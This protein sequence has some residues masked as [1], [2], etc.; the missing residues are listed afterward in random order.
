MVSELGPKIVTKGQPLQGAKIL[1]TG[2]AGQIAW[3]LCQRL[4][5]ANEVWGVA[6]FSKPG[7]RE[8]CERIGVHTVAADLAEGDLS[9]VPTDIDYLLHLAASTGGGLD[10]DAAIRA[11]AEATG[12]ILQHCRGVTAALVM[13]TQSV[14]EP[15][16]DPM[17]VFV[18]TDPLGD[19]RPPHAP[20]YGVSKLMSEGVA[21]A[22]SRMFDIPMTIARMNASYG[23]AGGLPI[24]HM[25]M[26]AN[27]QPVVT[28]W[29]PCMY[30]P[31]HA[32]DI[33]AH[34]PGLLAAATTPARIVNWGGDQPVSVQE[35]VPFMADLLGKR[36]QVQVVEAPGTLRGS[37]QDTTLREELAGPC[38]VDWRDGLRAIAQT[39]YS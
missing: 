30:S 4:V 3:D 23:P 2:P 32:D 20:T 35:W 34:V 37:I 15:W 29:D 17:H 31:I 11:N 18:E 6:R 19:P 12:R 27:D 24:I 5:G 7:S 36:A 38:R 14:Y 33:A 9:E 21:R 16:D 26:I 22:C 39:R 8:E 10:F 1:V 13:S 28:R 25:D